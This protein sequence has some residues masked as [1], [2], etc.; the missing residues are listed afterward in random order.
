MS[1]PTRPIMLKDRADRAGA[2]VA[3]MEKKALRGARYAVNEELDRRFDALV[4][5]QEAMM[6]Q[7]ARDAAVANATK[8]HE[9]VTTELKKLKGRIMEYLHGGNMRHLIRDEV[10]QHLSSAADR[11]GEFIAQQVRDLLKEEMELVKKE[12][13]ELA[14]Q[15]LMRLGPVVLQYNLLVQHL[16]YMTERNLLLQNRVA[17]IENRLGTTDLPRLA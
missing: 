2:K 1:W 8:L 7:H 15:I 10:S 17:A 9:H 12:V 6:K 13:G 4:V 11:S 3:S 5:N 14:E 16:A